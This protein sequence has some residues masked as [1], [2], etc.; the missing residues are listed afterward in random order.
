MRESATDMKREFLNELDEQESL[1]EQKPVV[2]LREDEIEIFEEAEL[3]ADE[4][5]R[6]KVNKV[7]G[8]IATVASI[9]LGLFSVGADMIPT[10]VQTAPTESPTVIERVVDYDDTTQSN[11]YQQFFTDADGNP[12]VATVKFPTDLSDPTSE[13]IVIT[14]MPQED[15][16]TQRIEDIKDLGEASGDLFDFLSAV[17][18]NS[19][20]DGEPS[21]EEIVNALMRQ[22]VPGAIGDPPDDTP[23]TGMVI[24]QDEEGNITGVT[25]NGEPV[26]PEEYGEPDFDVSIY[27]SAADDPCWGGVD[28]DLNPFSKDPPEPA[29][30]E[31]PPLSTEPITDVEPAPDPVID[32]LPEPDID[33]VVEPSGDTDI[34]IGE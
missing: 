30:T 19:R 27:D 31:E 2:A 24:Q 11:Q 26:P 6:N 12:R 9:P 8:N 34:D 20:D 17:G 28:V 15:P 13:P 22:P 16:A 3:P 7:V 18:E 25:I 14:A 33:P 21:E 10:P 29:I 1:N 23:P 32:E 4:V 5:A